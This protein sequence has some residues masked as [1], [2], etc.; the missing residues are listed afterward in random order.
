[1]PGFKNTSVYSKYYPAAGFLYGR[2]RNLG[3][4]RVLASGGVFTSYEA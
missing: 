2:T 3:I 1:M 4:N